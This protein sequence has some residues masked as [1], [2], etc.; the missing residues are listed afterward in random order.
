MG[1][2]TQK[3]L[4]RDSPTPPEFV[5]VPVNNIFEFEGIY[6]IRDLPFD[7]YNVGGWVGSTIATLGLKTVSNLFLSIPMLDS[8][9]VAVNFRALF[10]G[11]GGEKERTTRC[12]F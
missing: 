5:K 11:K 12:I 9:Q 3:L 10:R 4:F 8:W 1:A 7:G 2:K 6:Y